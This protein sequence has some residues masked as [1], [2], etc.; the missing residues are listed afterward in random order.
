MNKEA[1]ERPLATSDTV[2]E[3]FEE[4]RRNLPLR[5]PVSTYRLQFNRSFRFSD[6]RAA[7]PYLHSLGISDIYASPYFKAQQGSM[8]GYDI[9]DQNSLNPEVG[10]EEE[11]DGLADALKGHGMGQ[12]LDIVPNHMG[13]GSSGNRWWLDVLENGPSSPYASYF[14]IDWDPIKEEL[15]NKVLLPI[16]GDQY[17]RVLENQEL[18]LSFEAGA[19]LINYYEH[20]LPVEPA[21]YAQILQHRTEVLE[22]ALG[23]ED[24]HFQEFLSIITALKHLP[25]RSET[26][27]EKI[28]ERLREK[29]IIKKRLL[30][31]YEESP[32][33]RTFLDENIRIFNGTKHI[34]G[35]FD[36][37]DALLY[38]QVYRLSYWQVATEEINYRRFFDINDLAAIRMENPAVF[39]EVHRLVFNLIKEGKVTGLRVD[40]P[41]GLHNPREYFRALQEE[42]FIQTCLGAL[43]AEGDEQAE[44]QM[45]EFYRSELG[46]DPGLGRPF[47]IVGEKILIDGET[48]PEDWQI[49]GTTG[50][51]FMNS[52]NGLFVD[53]ANARA[54]DNIYS[55]YTR[56]RLSF[57]RLVHEKKELIMRTSM[58]SEMNVLG[59]ELNRIS[60]KDRRYRDFTLNDLTDAIVELIAFFPVYRTYI[61]AAGPSERDR[62][63]VNTAIARAKRYSR[64]LSPS[65]FEFLRSVLLLEYPD[66]FDEER[67]RQW[68]DFTMKFQQLTGPVMAKGLEDTVFYVYNRLVSLNAVGGNPD[69]FGIPVETFHGHNSERNERWP[70]TL[71][72]T[73]T[74]DS[75]RSED[76]RARINVISELPEEWK[77]CLK[78]WSRTTKKNKAVLEGQLVPDRNEEY[79][80]YQT[81]LGAWPIGPEG[82]AGHDDFRQRI[83]QYM[84]KAAKEAKVNTSW[85]NPNPDY[86]AALLGFVDGVMQNSQFLEDFREFRQKVSHFGAFNSLSQT[87]LKITS[88]GV[89]DFYQG[90][91]LWDLSLVDPD[92]RRPVD[93]SLGIRALSNLRALEAGIGPLEL[94]RELVLNWQDG[95]I[96]LYLTSKALNLRK[97]KKGLFFDG[98]YI[99][100]KAGGSYGEHLVAFV[101]AKGGERA[102]TVVPRLLAG[103]L[104]PGELPLADVW[105]DS[106]IALPFD[107]PGSAYRDIFSG[108]TIRTVEKDGGAALGVSDL[109][110]SFPVSLLERTTA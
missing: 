89:P 62:F 38:S 16:L 8:H 110:Y 22:A 25:P 56:S 72:T 51:V 46:K 36:L 17:G 11:Y 97:D 26:N 32:G 21:T 50:Y 80:L 24:P 34:Q 29:E 106:Y 64:E 59:H 65:I 2:R 108:R 70:H 92:N 104:K 18:S 69:R 103:L 7:V 61:T 37:L 28:T 49:F 93:Y 102:I 45:R 63:Y 79:L 100:L 98:E 40:H 5:I 107:K 9:V 10:D 84:I 96:K 48:L 87:L 68:L 57:E 90:T 19:F 47:Y 6:A 78:R 33:F 20:R 99:A 31:L 81:L 53:S 83:K 39:S 13:I 30:D 77:D 71:I 73:S 74:H 60:E 14:D 3:A 91:E 75:K 12:I 15:E 44:G 54:I 35:S 94:T 4:V 85:I 88:P 58:S 101:R 66:K 109:L 55:R 86:E 23:S 41:D 27:P 43:G 82:Q 52:V 105:G 1:Q 95:R 42:C 76:V 67:K